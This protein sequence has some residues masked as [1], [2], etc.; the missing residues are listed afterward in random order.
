MNIDAR[1][2]INNANT[3]GKYSKAFLLRLYKLG[4]E[5]T[6]FSEKRMLFLENEEDMKYFKNSF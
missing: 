4:A 5:I 1:I 2:C 3:N 6:V